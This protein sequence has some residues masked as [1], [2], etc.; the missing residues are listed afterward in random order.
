MM[1]GSL[2]VLCLGLALVNTTCWQGQ[3]ELLRHALKQ[4][5]GNGAAGQ[6]IPSHRFPGGHMLI[7]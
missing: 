3:G 5:I 7:G 4:G 6:E 2:A 1:L